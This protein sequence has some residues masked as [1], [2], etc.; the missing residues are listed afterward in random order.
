MTRLERDPRPSVCTVDDVKGVRP[1]P[2]GRV[3]LPAGTTSLSS[4][5]WCIDQVAS[6]AAGGVYFLID[7]RAYPAFYGVKRNDVA[8]FF[9]RDAYAHAGYVSWVVTGRLAPGPHT[10]AVMALS[11][12]RRRAFAPTEPLDIQIR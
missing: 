1:D 2:L 11:H 9:H 8:S 12:D 4:A 10:F 6:S 7:G 3:T 5:G